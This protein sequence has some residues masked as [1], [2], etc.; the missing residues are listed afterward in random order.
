MVCETSG[1]D[2][3]SR[4][5]EGAGQFSA[6]IRA[7]ELIGRARGLF[8][9]RTQDVEIDF[10]NLTPTQRAKVQQWLEEQAFKDDPKGLEGWRKGAPRSSDDPIQ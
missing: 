1:L 7:E 5:A 3:L 9:E 10:D 2:A 8:I 4:K 6:A